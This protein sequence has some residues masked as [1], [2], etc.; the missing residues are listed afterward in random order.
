[1]ADRSIVVRLTARV[2][3]YIAG[4]REAAQS[5]RDLGDQ[6]ED[7][8]RRQTGSLDKFS[9]G[10][11]VA[12][13]VLALGV[14]AAVKVFADFDQAMS[15]VKANLDATPAELDALT[16]SVRTVGTQFGFSATESAGAAEELAKAGLSAQQIIGGGLRGALT[17]AA[18]GGVST[19]DAATYAANAMS[20]FG[21][22]ASDVGHIA[23]V[24]A[25][26][27]NM[28][29]ASVESLAQGMSQGG[30]VAAQMGLNLQDTVGVLAMFDQAGLKGSDAGTSLKTMLL[31]LEKPSKQAQ[32]VMDN[33]GLTVYDSQGK[34]VG[35]T[36]FAG[37]LQDKMKDLDPATR[38]AALAT[39]F[40]T[41]AVRAASVVYQNGA[42]GTQKWI[43]GVNKSGT[44]AAVASQRQNNLNGDLK[45]LQAGFQNLFIGAG[46]GANGPGRVAVQW[47]TNFV[48][49]LGKLPSGATA[50]G[51][52]I[53]AL[54]GGSLLAASA[55][56][57]LLGTYR[58]VRT[59]IT[60]ARAA[61]TLWSTAAGGNGSLIS[62]L[63][64]KVQT[65]GARFAAMSTKTKIAAGI[66]A[67]SILLLGAAMTQTGTAQ[68]NYGRSN[69]Q[70]NADILNTKNGVADTSKVFS[71][72]QIAM[73]G[74]RSL[75]FADGLKVATS[76]A[77]GFGEAIGKVA[78]G[79]GAFGTGAANASDA[80]KDRLKALGEQLGQMVQD[81]HAKEAAATFDSYAKQANAAGV[82]TAELNKLMP[83]YASAV[84]DVANKQK[85]AGQTGQ[86]NADVLAD[87]QK[88]AE[89]AK[90]AFDDLVNSIKNLGSAQ[91]DQR[92][93]A[94]DYQ[95]SL[96]DATAS[97]KKNGRTLDITTEKGRENQSNLDGLAEST[98]KWAGATL[99]STGS[100]AQANSIL[101]EG[102]KQY[103]ATAQSMGMS[104]QAAQQLADSLFKLPS[105]ISPSVKV[106]GLP[107][108]VYSVDKLGNLVVQ[109]AGKSISIPASAPNAEQ[110]ATLLYGIQG[111][112]TDSQGLT[113]TIPT[114]ALGADGTSYALANI[115]GARLDANGN[116]AI[117]TSA[118]AAESTMGLLKQIG[119]LATDADGKQV[120][121]PSSAP[122][123]PLVA[124]LINNIHGAQIATNGKSVVITSSAPLAE[125]T[126]QKINNIKGA[127]VSADGRSVI[128]DS[129]VSGYASTLGQINNILNSAQSKTITIQTNFVSTVKGYDPYGTPFHRAT[130]GISPGEG[131]SR[132]AAGGVRPAMIASRP[133]LW[134]E[135]GPEAYLPLGAARR[136][137]PRTRQIFEKSAQILGYRVERRADG[138][139]NAAG[140]QRGWVNARRVAVA[141]GRDV[142]VRLHADDQ[143]LL[144]AAVAGGRAPTDLTVNTNLLLDG[145]V[146]A[147]STTQHQV[148]AAVGGSSLPGV[149]V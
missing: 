119:A 69:A 3:E 120:I 68:E 90:K 129:S 134:A 81:G 47:A 53:A 105:D 78:T 4:M 56:I 5:T 142:T 143:K 10:A 38:N 36:N 145:K 13:G 7:T 46:A 98:T 135:A 97:L 2:G 113:V 139:L 71:D 80:V 9:K 96:D 31:S 116:V 44:A 147:D 21:L 48:S 149:H 23:D 94:R 16:S 51:L 133:I 39:I 82:S 87:Q 146:V 17:L 26:G 65:L 108:A 40:G 88:K 102:K 22:K 35:L 66:A 49:V 117:P 1:M 67:T 75:S 109:I 41:D 19:G 74:D 127:Q 14:G 99:D 141:G 101:N 11:A 144:R 114:K 61:M 20:M 132:M 60:E 34:F 130:G 28:S 123:A 92:G 12:G 79:F 55:G 148:A 126:K 89:E 76:T 121:I 64:A 54:T 50:A 33:L 73:A 86:S 62:G 72:L 111:A 104:K 37:Q 30:M 93:S 43:D 42:A 95:Q 27:A 29:T 115:A 77:G 70:L 107:E 118:L 57:K 18:A 83:G 100:Q 8:E 63:S 32:I 52:G 58:E 85:E 131:V 137:A 45:K 136:N 140:V 138:G 24:L 112:V 106:D 91:L 84:Q 6:T 103:I 15:A 110:T 125:A 59:G 122:N 128:I 124:Q 25:N